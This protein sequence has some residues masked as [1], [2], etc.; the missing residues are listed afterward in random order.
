MIGS[1]ELILPC[2]VGQNK[3]FY[4]FNYSE[5]TCELNPETEFSV[6][7]VKAPSPED[8]RIALQKWVLSRCYTACFP[9]GLLWLE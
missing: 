8:H 4:A 6:T 5:E 2:R 9:C 7:Y 1:G 3:D